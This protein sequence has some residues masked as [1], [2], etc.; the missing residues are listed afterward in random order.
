M[1]ITTLLFSCERATNECSCFVFRKKNPKKPGSDMEKGKEREKEA[2]K[3]STK[4]AF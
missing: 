1:K 2:D 4:D 3:T